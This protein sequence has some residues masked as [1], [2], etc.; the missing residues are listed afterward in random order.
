MDPY[1]YLTVFVSV[2]LGLAG[3]V[4]L[5]GVDG[6]GAAHTGLVIGPGRDLSTH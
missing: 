1:E 5:L 4:H 3:G 2:V 6:S